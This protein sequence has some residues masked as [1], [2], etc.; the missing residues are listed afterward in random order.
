MPEDFEYTAQ[1]QGYPLYIIAF[2][3]EEDFVGKSD[4]RRIHRNLDALNE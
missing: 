4:T 2:K 3:L 1:C